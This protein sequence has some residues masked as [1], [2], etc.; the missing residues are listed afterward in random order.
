MP[1]TPE[2]SSSETPAQPEKRTYP[3]P[4]RRGQVA[5][6]AFMHKAADLGFAV[7]KP[8]GD[9]EAYDFILDS[10]YRLLRVQVR[11]TGG[12]G[13]YRGYRLHTVHGALTGRRMPYDSSQIDFLV[14]YVV[15][16]DA[17]Y[18]IPIAALGARRSITLY[19]YNPSSKGLFEKFREAWC[20]MACPKD[21]ECKKEIGVE[22]LCEWEPGRG[23]SGCPKKVNTPTLTSQ[24][25]LR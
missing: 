16:C 19:T 7:T 2:N 5:E 20:L 24:K 1:E 11:S 4:K 25:A 22:R 21:G 23:E 18:V 6:L 3:D 14:A 9:S 15:P 10:G 12:P 13:D 8:Y 17:W